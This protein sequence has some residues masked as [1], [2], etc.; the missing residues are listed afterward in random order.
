[1]IRKVNFLLVPSTII[2]PFVASCNHDAKSLIFSWENFAG[3]VYVP[4][5]EVYPE[6][7]IQLSKTLNQY[8][9][10]PNKS[11]MFAK[12]A[13]HTMSQDFLGSSNAKWKY[14]AEISKIENDLISFSMSIDNTDN[15]YRTF[16]MTIKN[17]PYKAK[18][19]AFDSNKDTLVFLPEGIE[20]TD[21]GYSITEDFWHYMFWVID[22]YEFRQGKVVKKDTFNWRSGFSPVTLDTLENNINYLAI[23]PHYFDGVDI[24]K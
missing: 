16:Y 19:I 17:L 6:T 18:L 4:D 20:Y 13:V 2:I 12:D 23:Y 24:I 1:M 11:I 22:I 3:Q 15:G 9:S 5:Y 7:S 8:Q 14:C 21:L 10:N